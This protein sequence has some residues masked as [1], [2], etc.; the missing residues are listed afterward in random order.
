MRRTQQ[1]R[2]QPDLPAASPERMRG[3][4]PWLGEVGGLVLPQDIHKT[5]P[6]CNSAAPCFSQPEERGVQQG[7]P[8]AA[9]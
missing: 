3:P 1:Q 5:D 8:R 7:D 2:V 6:S 9:L 4:V